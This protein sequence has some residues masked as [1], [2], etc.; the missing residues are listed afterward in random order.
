MFKGRTARDL[1]QVKA[2]PDAAPIAD[3]NFSRAER[4]LIR[5]DGYTADG[6]IPELS[7]RLLNR[8]GTS[9]ADVPVQPGTPGQGIV[10]LGL[11]ALAAGDYV[12]ELN[13]KTGSGSAKQLVAFKISR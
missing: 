8:G 2:N 13:A 5:V 7:A 10:E 1:Q 12:I 4:L 6:S 9:M 3:R 11:S